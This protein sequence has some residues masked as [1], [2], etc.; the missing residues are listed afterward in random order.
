MTGCAVAMRQ[1][2]GVTFTAYAACTNVGTA[3]T[4]T[5]ANTVLKA[6]PYTLA[7]GAL[8]IA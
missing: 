5:V 4:C 1:S 3:V 2:D 7:N 6:A 8:V